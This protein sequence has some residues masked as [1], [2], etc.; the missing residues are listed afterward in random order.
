[1]KVI[2]IQFVAMLTMLIDH[3]GAVWY[4]EDPVWRIIGRFALPLYIYAMVIGYFRTRDAY[5]YL[6]RVGILA[7]ISQIPYQ[8]AFEVLEINVIATLFVCLLT[9]RLL[10]WLKDKPIAG[11]AVTAAAIAL[12]EAFPF[13]YGAYAL[14]LTLIFR[15]A[16]PRYFVALH[17]LLNIASVF[18]KGWVLQ[19]F[20][21]MATIWI[22][23]LPDLMKSMDK[24]KIPR[25]VWRS[26]YPLHLTVIAVVHYYGRLEEMLGP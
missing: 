25:I 13:D 18:Y 9:L 2:A 16:S 24:I 3:I 21:L 19:L 7:A 14:L 11:V 22:V 12:L 15:Y 1:M 23:Y 8:L 6:T 17:L 26:F 10:D 20:S 4:P 5:R